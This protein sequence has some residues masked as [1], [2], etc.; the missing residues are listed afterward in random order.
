MLKHRNKSDSCSHSNLLEIKRDNLIG[1]SKASKKGSERVQRSKNYRPDI[2]NSVIH[3]QDLLFDDVLIVDVPVGDYID[4]VVIEGFLYTLIN[5]VKRQEHGNVNLRVVTRALMITRQNSDFRVNCTCPDF[6]YRFRVWATKYGYNYGTPEIRPAKITNPHDKLGSF[7]KH[8]IALLND[9][10][11]FER[12]AS[13]V[14]KI[15]QSEIPAIREA[16][17]LKEQDFYS[18]ESGVNLRYR[19]KDKAR[20]RVSDS[21]DEIWDS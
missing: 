18:Q 10:R 15:V 9:K 16:Y 17:G 7:C 19:N 11:W 8:L 6:R 12:L 21:E 4:T 20:Q 3:I 13:V 5:L 2:N 1:K 14:N